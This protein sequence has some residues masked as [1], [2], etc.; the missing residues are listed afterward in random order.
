MGFHNAVVASV[1]LRSIGL[2]PI[3]VG[4]RQLGIRNREISHER[5]LASLQLAAEWEATKKI[6]GRF[7]RRTAAD[8]G[9]R[10]DVVAA[11]AISRR[12]KSRPAYGGD[13][14]ASGSCRA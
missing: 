14:S 8:C 3:K 1:V 9:G 4:P 11:T 10:V 6:F 12:G 13:P 5:T 7:W 2:Y